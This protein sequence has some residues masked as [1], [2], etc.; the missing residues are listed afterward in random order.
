MFGLLKPTLPDCPV[1]GELMSNVFHY[2]VPAAAKREFAR[3]NRYRP[4]LKTGWYHC[5]TCE[6]HIHRHTV[7][8]VNYE[9]DK[10]K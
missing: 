2:E 1:C 4:L 8:A 10:R 9:R 7:E 5:S 3:M 6:L